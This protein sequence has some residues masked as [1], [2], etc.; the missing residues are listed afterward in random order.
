MQPEHIRRFHA[1]HYQL[2]NMGVVA[3]VP[4]EM[5]VD[6][7]LRRIGG[8]LER[9]QGDRP[10]SRDFMTEDRLPRPQ[11]APAGDVRIVD[12]PHQNAQQPSPLSSPGRR[13]ATPAPPNRCS[14]TSSSPAFAG[15]PTTNLYRIF[16]DGNTREIDVGARGVG[17]V[18]EQRAGAA[19]LHLALRRLARAHD[20]GAS[21]GG[22][23]PHPG[24]A[25]AASPRGRT[26][27]PSWR[28]STPG[29]AA[30]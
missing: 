14:W 10:V 24:R 9:L 2:G 19:R 26:D 27:R 22:A 21:G 3:S 7:V 18:D 30:A 25:A 28:R 17:G 4:R 6:A 5:T 15:D 13:S 29:C 16:V 11:S 1:D 20:R 8:T 12:Y 23:R